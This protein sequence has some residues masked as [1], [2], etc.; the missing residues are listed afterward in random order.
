MQNIYQTFD[1]YK[2][3]E[4][5]LE[6]AKTELGKIYIE[7]LSML[8]NFDLVKSNLS[9]LDEMMS[10][11]IRFGPLPIS[12]SANAIRL[13]DM[14]KKTALLTPHDLNLV[15]EDVITIQRIVSYFQK[16][17][18]SYARLKDLSAKFY[19]LSNLEKE[20]HR[21]ITPSLTVADNA[22]PELKDIRLSI[23]KL[24]AKLQDK[25]ATL[26]F[27]YSAYL[28]DENSTIRDG[29]FVLPVKT[30]DKNKVPGIIYDVSDSG[31]TTFI[32]PL[33]ICNINNEMTSL[34]VQENEEVRKVLKALTGL[35]LLQ[36]YEILENN[37][38]I[39][40][41]DFLQAKAMYANDIDAIV[42]TL[43]DKQEIDLDKARHPLIDKTKVISNSFHLDEEQRI[44][45][46]SGPNAGGKTVSLKTVGLHVLMTQCGLAIPANKATLGYFKHIFIDI[47]DNQ[48]LSDNLSTFSAHISQI[49]EITSLVGGKDLIL[50]DELGTGTD[51]KEGEALALSVTKYL[52]KKHT[53]CMISSHFE[54]LKEY[55]FTS[56]HIDNASMIFDEEKLLPT[57][58]F[59]Q[60]AAGHSYALW[61]A[62]KYG[63]DAAIIKEAEE[64]LSNTDKSDT[65]L[66]MD[67]LQKKLDAAV[68]LEDRLGKEKRDIE[69]RLKRL[70]SDE[71]NLKI[72]RDRLLEDVKDEKERLLKDAKGTIS[73]ILSKL[74]NEN[75]KLHEV[76]ELKKQLDELEENEE[77]L[78]YNEEIE[79]GDFVSVPSL[80][81][82]GKVERLSGSKAH[83]LC[84]NGMSFDV[85]KEKLHKIAKPKSHVRALKTNYDIAINTNVGLELN[86]IGLHVEEAENALIKYLDNCRL[87]RLTTVRIIHGF[88]SGALRKM[89]RAYLD[90]QKDLTYRAGGEH[91]GAGGA[92]VVT[93][94]K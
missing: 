84:D 17:D 29:H 19:D 76:I 35:V 39:A 48:S 8:D 71:S 32:E 15:A 47:G 82:N 66:L 64:Y 81:M 85:S 6:F 51:P 22:T 33:E 25:I 65:L 74:N 11:I 31:N 58:K 54:A 80:N 92:T 21:V 16:I 4:N 86:I 20:I 7:E 1:F 40:K 2:I 14:A 41:L 89:T 69:Y 68:K 23:K 91:E 37:S 24:E 70:E 60:G 43:S 72:R 44:I 52:E 30:V 73:F 9:D 87:K 3:Q 93:F 57:Y 61:V 27:S 49:S 38:I 83:I 53:L 18:V 5:L 36:E 45:V 26:A 12:N 34:K 79:V 42:P 10:L 78:D 77:A 75:I 63:I 13:I 59:H 56:N 28:N 94:K 55:A 90:K 62:R 50:F 67:T 88:G 46:I